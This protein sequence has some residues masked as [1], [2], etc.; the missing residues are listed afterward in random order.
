MF[1]RYQGPR[2]GSNKK[3]RVEARRRAEEAAQRR[4]AERDGQRAPGPDD[5]TKTT[6]RRAAAVPLDGAL[7]DDSGARYWARVTRFLGD[8]RA[9]PRTRHAFWWLLHNCLAH[10]LLGAAPGAV[11]V[12]LH[13]WTSD[14]L[15]RRAVP[16]RSPLP[17]VG[18]RG[19]WLLHNCVVHPLLGVAPRGPVFDLHDASAR[20]MDVADWV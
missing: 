18:R 14:G 6:Q 19:H 1:A 9:L 15:N 7:A 13:D 2:S 4:K 17:R 20:A 12:R 11:T 16:S 5:A 10:P 8:G 3:K